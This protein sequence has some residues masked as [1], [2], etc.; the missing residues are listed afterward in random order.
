MSAD[1]LAVHAPG[2]ADFN[3]YAYVSGAVLKSVDP[4]GLAGRGADGSWVETDPSS[5]QEG[6][7]NQGASDTPSLD[8][9]NEWKPQS[10][11]PFKSTTAERNIGGGGTS[12]KAHAAP[13]SSRGGSRNARAL[14]PSA[15]T[16]VTP[17]PSIEESGGGAPLMPTPPSNLSG[18]STAGGAPPQEPFNNDGVSMMPNVP[19]GQEPKIDSGAGEPLKPRRDGELGY[20]GYTFSSTH[21][22]VMVGT[23]LG[24]AAGDRVRPRLGSGGQLTLGI[25]G[26]TTGEFGLYATVGTHA[27]LG[28]NASTGLVLGGALG[29]R[30]AFEGDDVAATFTANFVRNIA[31]AS[32]SKNRVVEIGVPNT[33]FGGG[34]CGGLV[35]TQT[36]TLKLPNMLDYVPR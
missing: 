2:E 16:P 4:V 22:A 35:S 26:T 15:G 1:P 12:G 20:V 33:G 28:A 29:G 10:D 19:S 8:S 31:S 6:A 36:S 3:L 34:I 9:Q 32:V 25:W 17:T 24:Q 30:K 7:P 27:Q 18:G 23:L 14:T 13:R 5:A 11:D 21:S